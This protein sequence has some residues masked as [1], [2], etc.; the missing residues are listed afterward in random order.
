MYFNRKFLCLLTGTMIL[1]LMNPLYTFAAE[2]KESSTWETP[3][4]I[5]GEEIEKVCDEQFQPHIGKD[6]AG[7]GIAMVKDGRIVFEKGY[8]YQDIEN[9]IPYDPEKTVVEIGS[10]SKLF[11]WTS[12][13]QMAEKG[14]LD[15][16]KDVDTYLPED[17]QM[18]KKYDDPVTMLDLMN[19]QGGYDDYLIHLFNKKDNMVSLKE[20]LEENKV[21]QYKR[22]G[23]A[24]SY[25]N[26][27]AG[28]A[29]YV[30]ESIEGRPFYEHVEQNI[31]QPLEMN[32]TIMNPDLETHPDL[33][34]SKAKAYYMDGNK[35]EEGN[36]TYVSMYP[37]G[38]MQSTLE[39]L[40]KFAMAFL[41]KSST[42]FEKETTYDEM[43]SQS[44][45]TPEGVEGIAHGFVEYD[46]AYKT[47]WHNGGTEYFSTF[48]AI[49]PD[50][51]F[52][53]IANTNSGEGNLDVIQEF[54]FQILQKKKIEETKIEETKIEEVKTEK[55]LPEVSIL[56][57]EYNDFR[58]CHRGMLQ[59][60]YLFRENMVVKKEAENLI[61][62]DGE[63]FQQIRPYVFQSKETGRR[64]SFTVENGTVI[65]MTQMLDYLPVSPWN[66]I[67]DW[68]ITV[69]AGL[70][71]ITC[72]L[73]LMHL[74]RNL[75]K[76]RKI[77][78]NRSMMIVMAGWVLLG[79]GF[80]ILVQRISSWSAL[81]EMIWNI[82]CNRILAGMIVVFCIYGMITQWSKEKKV[83]ILFYVSSL[84][85]ISAFINIGL[86][87]RY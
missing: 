22:P 78:L 59:C 54:C 7:V 16:H 8:G 21:Q 12:A 50:A 64:C 46:G 62:I 87:A 52:A 53:I 61:T 38:S 15:L 60:L 19:H 5:S 84:L 70:F 57:G 3:S 37:A 36:W 77:N 41:E 67:R 20:A 73:L 66:H 49:V 72:F 80:V 10:V 14:Q 51:D 42:L 82:W 71:V 45:L 9:Q 63:A 18:V 75:V 35:L 79:I 43:L 32:H 48:F 85:L 33:Q 31:L 58:E 24:S 17:F 28:L 23:M 4:G 25:S 13:M 11:T 39:D 34:K 6:V 68:G 81:P 30:V 76:R 40:S 44:Y 74:I 26:Y 2:N 1:E 65:K 86:F 47:Y 83:N 55:N 69:I 27:G 29:G 56:E